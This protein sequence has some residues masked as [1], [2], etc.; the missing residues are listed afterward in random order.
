MYIYDTL[1]KAKCTSVLVV[2]FR[3]GVLLEHPLFCPVNVKAEAQY[4]TPMDQH[5]ILTLSGPHSKYKSIFDHNW[6]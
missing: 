4:A 1:K 6:K 5:I 2:T 3:P